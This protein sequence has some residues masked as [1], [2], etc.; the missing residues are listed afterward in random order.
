MDPS[1]IRTKGETVGVVL[2]R[3][4]SLIAPTEFTKNTE[5]KSVIKLVVKVLDQI[6][7]YHESTTKI[8]K[9]S[10][11]TETGKL[12]VKSY[13]RLDNRFYP[14]KSDINKGIKCALDQIKHGLFNC[15]TSTF[16]CRNNLKWAEEN[17]RKKFEE[18]IKKLDANELILDVNEEFTS[19][20]YKCTWK[21]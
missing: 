8:I 14:S 13:Y 19:R 6:V 18:S 4:K 20:T 3:Y 5:V 2:V 7:I 21:V 15:I 10:D 12:N 11:L 9:P 17:N 1:F 16:K